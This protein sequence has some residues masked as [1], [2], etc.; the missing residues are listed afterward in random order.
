MPSPQRRVQGRG[1]VLEP[2][3]PGAQLSPAAEQWRWTCPPARAAAAPGQ[4]EFPLAR[5]RE[6]GSLAGLL[7]THLLSGHV[8]LRRW[9]GLVVAAAVRQPARKVLCSV[10]SPTVERAPSKLHRP[11]A[12]CERGR[13]PRGF[14]AASDPGRVRRGRTPVLREAGTGGLPTEAHHA[15]LRARAAHVILTFARLLTSLSRLLA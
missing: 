7:Q 2:G 15:G 4:H 11:V 9:M 8:H 6:K 14:A 3:P 12:V 1:I 13:R 10:S 5:A